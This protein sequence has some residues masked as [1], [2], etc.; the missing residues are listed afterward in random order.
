LGFVVFCICCELL[1]WYC[2]LWGRRYNN[3]NLR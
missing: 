1:C 2:A 3:K